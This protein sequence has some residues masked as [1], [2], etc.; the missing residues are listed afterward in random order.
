[1]FHFKFYTNELFLHKII[2][3]RPNIV[4]SLYIIYNI[5]E[6]KRKIYKNIDNIRIS[7]AFKCTLFLGEL[8]Y[9]LDI[10]YDTR[11]VYKTWT[12][13]NVKKSQRIQRPPLL[14]YNS[15]RS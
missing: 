3:H 7:C 5:N 1:M 13:I 15:V 9:G 4:E 11:I 6:T 12:E 8:P 14:D 2:L 10:F